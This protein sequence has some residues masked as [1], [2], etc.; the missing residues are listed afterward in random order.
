MLITTKKKYFFK[1]GEVYFSDEYLNKPQNVDVIIYNQATEFRKGCKK[2]HTLHI[3]LNKNEEKLFSDIRK[4]YRRDIRKAME[5][6]KLEVVICQNPTEEDIE[7]FCDFYNIFA[8]NK[9]LSK[10]SVMKLKS[11][12]EKK[13]LMI[14]FTQDK[15]GNKLCYSVNII[16]GN[17]ARGLY[18]ASYFRMEI[19]K[20]QRNLIGRANKYL[21]WTEIK[22]LKEAGYKIYDLGGVTLDKKNEEMNNIDFFKIGFG[23]D[24]ITEY[25][26]CEAKNILGRLYKLL[27]FNRKT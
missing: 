1:I 4:T 27:I 5:K 23:G 15:D 18:G 7:E 10:S 12:K 26:Y 20:K 9:N 25:N 6:D 3:N 13:G 2:F 11:L 14:N 17:R 24:V 16:D 21:Y 19:D 8:K 22:F